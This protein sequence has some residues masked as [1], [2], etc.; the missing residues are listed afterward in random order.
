LDCLAAAVAGP[1]CPGETLNPKLAALIQK[2]LGKAQ[3]ALLATRTSTKPRKTAKLV[4]RARKQLDKVGAQADAFVTKRK[5][6]ISAEC[7]DRIRSE[8]GQVTQQIDA[9]R[10]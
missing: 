1:L 2:K 6:P 10:I 5:G 4:A 3:A 7:R 8:L 9:N